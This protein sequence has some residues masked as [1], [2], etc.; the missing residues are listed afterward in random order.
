M[1]ELGVTHGNRTKHIAKL[2]ADACTAKGA[3]LEQAKACGDKFEQVF[4]KKKKEKKPKKAKENQN[5]ETVEAEADVSA[6][7]TDTLLFL[8]PKEV[9]I[10]AE[11]FSEKGFDPN[12]VITQKD[13]KKQAKEVAGI[14]GDVNQAV[15]ALDI[16]LFGRMVAQAAELNVEAAASFA[17]A[18]STHKVSNEV[19][20]FTALDDLQEDPGAHG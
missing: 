20:F 10:I 9:N 2:I 19:E 12:Q 13:A 14:I 17:H 16:A 15:D 1:H 3:T 6:E 11:A 8:S 7:K 5:V 18:I 4:I